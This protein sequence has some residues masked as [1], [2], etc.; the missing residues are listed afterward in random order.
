MGW[1]TSFMM[2]L[3]SVIFAGWEMFRRRTKD[4]LLFFLHFRRKWNAVMFNLHEKFKLKSTASIKV[5]HFVGK[6][7]EVILIYMFFALFFRASKQNGVGGTQYLERYNYCVFGHYPS[8]CFYLN[9]Y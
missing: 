8:S 3:E 5:P 9:M 4:V 2:G 6:A 1:H 7:L